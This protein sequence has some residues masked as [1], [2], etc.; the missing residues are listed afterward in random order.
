MIS[1]A[2]QIGAV[3]GYLKKK[4]KVIISFEIGSPLIGILSG[5]KK[6]EKAMANLSLPLLI[7]NPIS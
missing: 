6:N 1:D 2:N 3:F 5:R 4:K 7:F